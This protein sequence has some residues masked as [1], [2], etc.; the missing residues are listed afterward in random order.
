MNKLINL[1]EYGTVF[2][3]QSLCTYYSILMKYFPFFLDY[4]F[5]L[6][7]SQFKCLPWTDF[8]A[9]QSE[10]TLFFSSIP[11]NM[12]SIPTSLVFKTLITHCIYFLKYSF[13]IFL[14]LYSV[15]YLEKVTSC[16]VQAARNWMYLPHLK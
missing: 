3:A 16:F 2:L 15:S 12:F 10:V 9:T 11:A 6:F 4:H 13:R 5:S 8:L 7:R 1:L 14:P